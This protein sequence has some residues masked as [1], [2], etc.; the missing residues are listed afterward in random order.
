MPILEGA[1]SGDIP[2]LVNN[3]VFVCKIV[4]ENP[5]SVPHDDIL[6]LL[7][8]LSF[9]PARYSHLMTIIISSIYLPK[10]STR[11]R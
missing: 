1:G 3:L 11:F 4:L 2:W 9:F 8:E 10:I 6:V 7:C 5:F